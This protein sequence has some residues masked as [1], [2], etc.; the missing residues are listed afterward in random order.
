MAAVSKDFRS[1]YCTLKKGDTAILIYEAISHLSIRPRMLLPP[2]PLAE[3][4]FQLNELLLIE[5]D[6]YIPENHVISYVSVLTDYY[7]REVNH[8]PCPRQQQGL[9]RGGESLGR[10]GALRSRARARLAT[11]HFAKYPSRSSPLPQH[12]LIV[13]RAVVH[14]PSLTVGPQLVPLCHTYPVRGQL[15]LDTYGRELFDKQWD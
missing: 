4:D 11:R 3:T 10:G 8:D 12:D 7:D 6:I 13:R 15:E 1:N 9:S 2:Y 14:S 5:D